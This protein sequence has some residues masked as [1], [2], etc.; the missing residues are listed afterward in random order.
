MA[1]K[2]IPIN[3]R[4]VFNRK[5]GA[6]QREI[7]RGT[8]R[9]V[10]REVAIL[11][12]NSLWDIVVSRIKT[13]LVR[14][15]N[16]E[17]AAIAQ[18][19]K[20]YIIGANGQNSGVTGKLESA[21]GDEH[22]LPV[23]QRLNLRWAPRSEDYMM[24][25]ISQVGHERWFEH[26]EGL[27]RGVPNPVSGE[28]QN[29]MGRTG[30]WTRAFGPV[31]VRVTRRS[32]DLQGSGFETARKLDVGRGLTYASEVSRLSIGTVTVSAFGR[33]TPTMLS[34]MAP[35]GTSGTYP[36]GRDTGLI[37]LLPASI[38]YRLGGNRQ[39]VPYRAT[40]E[41]FLEFFLTRSLPNAVTRRLEDGLLANL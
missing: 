15:G 13:R 27:K 23:S 14:D 39:Y 6:Q 38:A 36:D 4:F 33:I 12:S 10:A 26:G 22:G 29:A 21:A 24:R 9:F 32:R 3:L 34:A 16:R 41:P 20:R 18:Q 2:T 17:I 1:K 37:G 19:Y 35:G 11:S 7:I 28:L 31:G 8:S 30:T 5:T 40:L 25:K